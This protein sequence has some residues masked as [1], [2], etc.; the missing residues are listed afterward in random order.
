MEANIGFPAIVSGVRLAV[1]KYPFSLQV[2]L[3]IKDKLLAL[4]TLAF[5][6]HPA[7]AAQA[8]TEVHPALPLR[9]A[10]VVIGCPEGKVGAVQ[11]AGRVSADRDSVLGFFDMP[12][13]AL[14]CYSSLLSK[15]FRNSVIS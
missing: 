12:S 3:T 2:L 10:F 6:N 9:D 7:T 8:K 4:S 5:M 14:W 15:N 13:F 11:L 1:K